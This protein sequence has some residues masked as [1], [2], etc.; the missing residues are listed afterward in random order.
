MDILRKFFAWGAKAFGGT[1]EVSIKRICGFIIIMCVLIILFLV[2]KK[3]V[4]LEVW[5]KIEDFCKFLVITAS[6][7]FGINALLDVA[8]MVKGPPGN[9]GGSPPDPTPPIG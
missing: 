6:A 9:P 4:P 5:A 1:D 8:K 7:F 2:A 3:T